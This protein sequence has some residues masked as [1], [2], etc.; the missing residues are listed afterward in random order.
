[1]QNPTIEMI[2]MIFFSVYAEYGWFTWISPL[3]LLDNERIKAENLIRNLHFKLRSPTEQTRIYLNKLKFA[4]LLGCLVGVCV[5][6]NV[7]ALD[8]RDFDL[9]ALAIIIC[10]ASVQ[11]CHLSISLFRM[12]LFV[13]WRCLSGHSRIVSKYLMQT[14]HLHH[15]KAIDSKWMKKRCKTNFR[16]YI[17]DIELHILSLAPERRKFSLSL[18]LPFLVRIYLFSMNICLSA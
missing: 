18:Y 7:Y 3:F 14:T 4:F 13:P 6:V 9:S 5:N 8:E 1:M 16:N 17:Y 11:V 2:N 12:T 10:D 15:I